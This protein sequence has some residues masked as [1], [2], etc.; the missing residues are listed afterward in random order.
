MWEFKQLEHFWKNTFI[1]LA[2]TISTSNKMKEE[3]HIISAYHFFFIC[4]INDEIKKKKYSSHIFSTPIYLLIL[5]KKYYIGV[6]Y[7]LHV[8]FWCAARSRIFFSLVL[9][10]YF[11]NNLFISFFS[12]QSHRCCLSA[13]SCIV[14]ALII[15]SQLF[16]KKIYFIALT[17][18]AFHTQ[19]TQIYFAKKKIKL[20]LMNTKKKK[21]VRHCKMIKSSVL[22]T[23][24][25]HT[26]LFPDIPLMNTF[27][28]IFPLVLYLISIHNT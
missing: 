10:F 27:T 17:H 6:I 15:I 4:T 13:S 2:V 3:T 16:G 12:Q 24:D 7:Y 8:L 11:V 5:L 23:L 21:N 28:T 18:Y 20:A 22:G 1:I 25:Y 14:A 19:H 9:S 26:S